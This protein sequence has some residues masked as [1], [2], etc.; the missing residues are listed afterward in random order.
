M[1]D[2]H[3]MYLFNV[4]ESYFGMV[5]NESWAYYA[6][7]GS[8]DFNN[9]RGH[10]ADNGEWAFGGGDD[11]AYDP[12]V[13]DILVPTGADADV[14]DFIL[15]SYDVSAAQMA[16]LLAVGPGLSFVEDETDP[17]VTISAPAATSTADADGA[18]SVDV[19]V[20]FAV[21]DPDDATF[22]GLA[23]VEV[24]VDGIPQAG[25]TL[26][27]TSVVLTL[28]ENGNVTITVRAT[29][30]SGNVG[31]ASVVVTV[32]GIPDDTTTTEKNGIPG[33]SGFFIMLVSIGVVAALLRKRN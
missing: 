15:N 20:T 31:T 16:V 4:P 5:A 12:N 24:L 6:M 13:C 7:V 25:V 27:T 29:D 19:T 8:A 18:A 9:F 22:S 3:Y 21:A 26:S 23:R 17:T 33:Y 10:N 30:A 28:E 14:Q 32:T 1:V 2:G 11:G